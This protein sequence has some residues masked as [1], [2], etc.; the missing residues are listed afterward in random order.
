MV[1]KGVQRVGAGSALWGRIIT[2]AE[3][4][5]LSRGTVLALHKH[6]CLLSHTRPPLEAGSAVIHT[7]HTGKLRPRVTQLVS[8]DLQTGCL[9]PESTLGDGCC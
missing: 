4:P 6:Q 5:V 1:V 7:L 2:N 3:L 8:R 9:V